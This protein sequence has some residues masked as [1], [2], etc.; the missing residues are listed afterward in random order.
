MGY[1]DWPK[2]F[3]GRTIV[4]ID[5]SDGGD[6][7][8]FHF[9]EPA[10][11]THRRIRE[12]LGLEEPEKK[13]TVAFNAYGDCCSVSWVESFDGAETLIGQIVMSAEAVDIPEIPRQPND[14]YDV[15]QDYCW[16][17]TSAAGHADLIFR[18]DS[19]GYYGGSLE[20]QGEPA[21]VTW[22]T[23]IR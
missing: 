16:R 4:G 22:T 11:D 19:N 15:V 5:I 3:V 21:G 17:F 23:K 6:Y 7:I 18:N 9:G 2:G 1:G 20:E 13:D 8:Q 10:Q 14:D 12:A